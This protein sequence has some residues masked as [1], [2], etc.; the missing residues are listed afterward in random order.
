MAL[1]LLFIMS[2]EFT[3]CQEWSIVSC[4]ALRMFD[5]SSAGQRNNVISDGCLKLSMGEIPDLAVTGSPKSNS[6]SWKERTQDGCR[7]F[8]FPLLRPLEERGG[9][10][11]TNLIR[12]LIESLLE[13]FGFYKR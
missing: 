11:F 6:R 1:N 2:A 8:H 10:R 9:E 3:R 4:T 5:P 7:R 13:S 12:A